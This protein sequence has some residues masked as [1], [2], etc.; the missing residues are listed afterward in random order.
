MDRISVG[1]RG[2]EVRDM[3]AKE[4]SVEELSSR[5]GGSN[6]PSPAPEKLPNDFTYAIDATPLCGERSRAVQI[7][8]ACTAT[9][10]EADLPHARYNM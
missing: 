6:R 1:P 2:F 4:R 3:L 9:S 8:A 5:R 7:S 10:I